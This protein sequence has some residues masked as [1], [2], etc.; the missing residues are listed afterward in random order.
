MKKARPIGRA[1]FG[2]LGMYSIQKVKVPKS[3]DNAKTIA[4]GVRR[5]AK[6]ERSQRQTAD[7]TKSNSIRQT[8]DSKPAKQSETEQLSGSTGD[9]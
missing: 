8:V 5:K 1:F 2:V 4:K 9:K 3:G 7:P 6:S